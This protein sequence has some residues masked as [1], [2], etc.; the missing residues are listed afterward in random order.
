[1]LTKWSFALLALVSVAMIGAG[2]SS[3]P[4]PADGG[5]AD[6]RDYI[7]DETL[8]SFDQDLRALALAIQRSEVD[9]E[10]SLRTKIS[11]SARLYQ[12]ALISALYDDS[13]TP[14]RALAS[15]ML[16]FTGDASV[17][18]PLIDKVKDEDEPESVR[19][20][21]VLGL[22]TLGDKLR[23][24]DKHGQLMSAF[25]SQMETKETSYAMRRASI[26]AYS[27]AY[28]GAQNDSILPLR[29]RFLSDP[30]VRVQIAAI[31]ALG[32]IGDPSAVPDL[33]IVGLKHPDPDLRAASAVALG[34]IADPT[35]VLPALADACQ[36]ENATVRRQ[37]IDAI[38]KHYGSDPE[39]V[40][41]TVITGL[42]DFDSR[43]RE[44]SALALAR[45]NDPRA[46]DSLLQA[47][48]DR[49]AV[50]R[51]AAAE[52]L[53]QL[54]TYDREKESFPLVELLTDQN[55]GVKASAL[56]SLTKVTREDFGADQER[57]QKYFY[58]KYPEL[59]PANMYGDG[60]KPRVNSG[61]SSSNSRRTT[62]SPS[63]TTRTSSRNTSTRNTSRN[64]TSRN[65]GRTNRTR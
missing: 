33:S 14:R 55:P 17:V 22:A 61:I 34:K 43:V 29:D 40:Y 42:S 27:V 12:K 7:E 64:N 28:D 60:P 11:E 25:S 18:S 24:F 45:L 26:L 65:T 53:G 58:K 13:S 6:Q 15:V 20:N 32:D 21:A 35:H 16:G 2:C 38:S 63:R 1:M 9:S 48:G 41:A 52:S 62:S 51:Q 50:V 46:I 36:D 47:T 5:T 57:W 37:A 31:N 19:L 8:E 54:I 56:G 59:D 30:D 39:R 49:T 10:R 3:T 23:D 4:S 44:A